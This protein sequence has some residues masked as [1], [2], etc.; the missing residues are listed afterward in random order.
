MPRLKGLRLTAQRRW[1]LPHV[2]LAL[3]LLLA[4][5]QALCA[6]RIKD[7]TSIGGVRD[8]QL[9]GYGIVTGL[10]GTGDSKLDFTNAGLA[11]VLKHFDI[12]VAPE[13][14]KS[15]NVAAVMLTANIGPFIREG[16]RIDVMVS[17]IGDAKSL[18][19][20]VL[21]QA[22][23]KG[24][25]GQVY[26]VAQGPIA[27]GGFFAGSEGAG[28]ASVQKNH[29]TVGMISAGA[30]VER[31]I[32]SDFDLFSGINLQLRNPDFTS[33]VRVADAINQ[34]YPAQ[35]MAQNASN[36]H[37]CIP[38]NFEG[39]I[40]NFIAALGQIETQTNLSA[41]IIVNER[42]G[43]IVA[44]PNVRICKVA[45]SHGSLTISVTSNSDVSQPNALSQGGKTTV[46]HS[47]QTGVNEVAGGFTIMDD[48]PTIERFA[49]AMN[50][51]G[52]SVRE[53]MPI[54]EA[55]K[56]AGALNAELIHA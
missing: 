12:K 42:T 26:A 35:A 29:P 56:Q 32:K 20:S 47:T 5:T 28:G 44:T 17:S 31:E 10:A 18:Q 25:D 48:F 7:I 21:M 33:A 37:V 36:V 55:I 27:V 19:G 46:T 53:M 3:L 23:L 6:Y 51:L 50:A 1:W 39:Q 24:A 2:F 30:I 49:A 41:R 4:L 45:V 52:V 16:T 11:N 22:P 38:K 43:T 9:V 14:I 8:N 13:A 15:K 54:L 40:V 34:H